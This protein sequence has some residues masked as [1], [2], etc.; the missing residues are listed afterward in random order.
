MWDESLQK[1]VKTHPKAQE[2]CFWVVAEE[3]NRRGAHDWEEGD[4]L[5]VPRRNWMLLSVPVL[6]A[7]DVHLL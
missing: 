6:S 3:E 1:E 5:M 2:V 4:L 7:K